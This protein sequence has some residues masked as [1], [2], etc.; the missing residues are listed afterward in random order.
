VIRLSRVGYDNT[1]GYLQG[2]IK[3]WKEAGFA[4]DHLK[5]IT[6]HDFSVLFELDAPHI[7]LLDARRKSEFESEH[8]LGAKNFPLDFINHNMAELDRNKK[9]FV[10]CAGGYRSVIMCSILKSRGFD[11]LVT[12]KGGYKL[13]SQTGLKK[14]H[15]VEPTT[16]L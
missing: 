16:M 5:E 6:A 11:H 4:T 2:G 9:Y 8:L 7:N 14:T 12:I 13:L 10:H 1:M 15:Y 3:A